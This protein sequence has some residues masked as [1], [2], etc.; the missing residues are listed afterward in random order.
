MRIRAILPEARDR[1]VD[2]AR[3]ALTHGFVV[4]AQPRDHAGTEVLDEDISSLDEPPQYLTTCSLLRVSAALRLLR[5]HERKY[6]LSPPANGGPNGGC[7]RP[8]L[9][10]RV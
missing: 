10:P 7:R 3:I 1:A 8:R 2:Q 5:W 9:A 4:E 6:A